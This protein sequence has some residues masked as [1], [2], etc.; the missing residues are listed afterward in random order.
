MNSLLAR[1]GLQ[2]T[3]AATQ[4]LFKRKGRYEAGSAGCRAT[5]VTT[6][7]VRGY[8]IDATLGTGE[9]GFGLQDE[10]SR[11]NVV[12]KVTKPQR[13]W[14]LDDKPPDAPSVQAT[15]ADA[16]LGWSQSSQD[17]FWESYGRDAE[18]TEDTNAAE[19]VEDSAWGADAVTE[20]DVFAARNAH[21]LNVD[22]AAKL[23]G[24]LLARDA[25]LVARCLFAAH[26]MRDLDFFRAIPDEQFTSIL[27]LLRPENVMGRGASIH[28]GIS[29]ALAL[30]LGVMEI[31][32]IA[33]SYSWTLQTI[34][35]VRG[36][37]GVKPSA[38]DYLLLLRAARSLGQKSYAERLWRRLKEDGHAP[39][40]QMYNAYMAAVVWAGRLNAASRQ[41]DRV[42]PF[43]MA[44]R[45][46]KWLGLGF[47]NFRVGPM[48][49][50]A[51][52]NDILKTMLKDGCMAD[53]E[54]FR[55]VITGAA[56]EG[57]MDVVKAVLRNVWAVDVD[58]LLAG[59]P[60][61]EMQPKRF[62]K[63][64]PLHPSSELLFTLAHAFGINNDIPAAL[65][66]VDF[67]A[68]NYELEITQKT[69]QTL[70]EWCF[71][72]ASKRSGTTARNGQTAGKLPLQ[73]VMSLWNTIAS[74][75]YHVTPTMEMYNRL[76]KNLYQ[77]QMPFHMLEM[78]RE[79]LT[80]H[81]QAVSE[82]RRCLRK[83]QGAVRDSEE[84]IEPTTPISLRRKYYEDAE[85]LRA[86]NHAWVRRWLALLLRTTESY[87]R[88]TLAP[89][90]SLQVLP[91]LSWEWRAFAPKTLVY[92]VPT[93]IVEIQMHSTD[94]MIRSAEVKRQQ[95][96]RVE[97]LISKAS[98]SIGDEWRRKPVAVTKRLAKANGVAGSTEGQ[99]GE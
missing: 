54:T 49:V 34:V 46:K 89:E 6:G 98:V 58:A 79:G 60:E 68:R 25:D 99:L 52:A 30:Q 37:A 53:E 4:R 3:R 38:R 5:A 19:P 17:A 90:F 61:S 95:V 36:V 39:D 27:E 51:Q 59:Q 69:W 88:L 50:R 13:G 26:H 92:D 14:G 20:G 78:M 75:P 56:K 94:D 64:E 40:T 42:T 63:D 71:V 84:G 1:F 72:L 16:Q 28:R 24:A 85:L 23:P 76:V 91:Q 45:S 7:N 35:S 66:V 32:Q 31:S 62:L 86:R 57:E 97:A 81:D 73:S 22:Y 77:R 83:L 87:N 67:L 55:L 41:K 44:A 70:F 8:A 96:E 18:V 2:E 80:L 65:R 15:S 29:P 11:P 82:A 12:R 47:M 10:E 74:A 43:H 93:G 21:L 48:G 9:F 33:R